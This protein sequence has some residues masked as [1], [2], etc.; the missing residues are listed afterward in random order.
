MNPPGPSDRRSSRAST[1]SAVEEVAQLAV[2]GPDHAQATHRK[3]GPTDVVAKETPADE[4]RGVSA[5][6][7]LLDLQP[8][9]TA[10]RTFSGRSTATGFASGASDV[11]H[12][13]LREGE[14]EASTP[15]LQR[16][17]A[18]RAAQNNLKRKL[19]KL[20]ARRHCGTFLAPTK[21]QKRSIAESES[22]VEQ[23]RD[24]AERAVFKTPPRSASV[25]AA[26]G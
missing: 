2:A 12:M 21:V 3:L 20:A 22:E 18:K 10:G 17:E 6:A 26:D 1:R 7:R 16:A 24:V 8:P 5:S 19:E 4:I 25:V 9:S 13:V 15:R 23:G 11:T 14:G